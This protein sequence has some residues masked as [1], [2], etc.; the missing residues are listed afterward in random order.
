M[1]ASSKIFGEAIILFKT[2]PRYTVSG[3]V[4]NLPSQVWSR[5]E[6]SAL[7]QAYRVTLMSWNQ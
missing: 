1:M 3:K 6:R 4:L 5:P 2:T 7:A